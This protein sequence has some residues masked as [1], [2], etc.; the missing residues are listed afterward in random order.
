[1][2]PPDS[3]VTVS[4]QMTEGQTEA[5]GFKSQHTQCLRDTQEGTHSRTAENATT[6]E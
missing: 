3:Q 4:T 5:A 1:M 2:S 6:Q